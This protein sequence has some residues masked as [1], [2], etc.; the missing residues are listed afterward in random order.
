MNEQ[1]TPADVL[2]RAAN[3]MDA[4][5]KC[6]GMLQS[7]DGR[8]CIHGAISAA[9]G[10]APMYW[11]HLGACSVLW[12]HIGRVVTSNFSDTVDQP[13]ATSTMR[14]AAALWRAQNLATP[15]PAGAQ[16]IAIPAVGHKKQTDGA[17]EQERQSA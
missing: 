1:L 12:D 13:T 11:A 6:N 15:D 10:S 9:V 5:G 4:H 16:E 3:Y 7:A 17:L 2:E 8:A 14:A